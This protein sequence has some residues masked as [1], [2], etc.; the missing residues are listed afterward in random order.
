M[1]EQDAGQR[2]VRGGLFII[3]IIIKQLDMYKQRD[4]INT[5][6]H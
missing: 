1:R 4:N 2:E 5:F 6:L 3:I